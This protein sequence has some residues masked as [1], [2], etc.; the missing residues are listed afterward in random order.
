[1]LLPDTA[2]P[3]L[4]ETIAGEELTHAATYPDALAV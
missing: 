3:G 2:N 4:A 1:M